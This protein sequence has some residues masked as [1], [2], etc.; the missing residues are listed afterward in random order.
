MSQP[1]SLSHTFAVILTA[2]AGTGWGCRLRGGAEIVGPAV[3][4]QPDTTTLLYPGHRARVDAYH[5]L[6]IRVPAIAGEVQS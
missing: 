5:N 2:R 3:A 1:L 4:E 6:I